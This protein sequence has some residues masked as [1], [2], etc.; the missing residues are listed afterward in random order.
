MKGLQRARTLFVV[1][2]KAVYEDGLEGMDTRA[3]ADVRRRAYTD[4]LEAVR[5]FNAGKRAE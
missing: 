5:A 2:D 3:W 4:W 1:A